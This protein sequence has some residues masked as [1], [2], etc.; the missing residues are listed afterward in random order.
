[1]IQSCGPIGGLAYN[2]TCVT[3]A[4]TKPTAVGNLLW[5]MQQWHNVYRYTGF[6]Q[7]ELAALFPL[8]ARA[9]TYYSHITHTNT[10]VGMNATTLHLN[11]T[12]S[13]AVTVRAC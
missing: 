11:A 4:G 6:D 3:A 12:V 10:S 9:V 2:G 5:A 8:L 7:V 1:M 13:P